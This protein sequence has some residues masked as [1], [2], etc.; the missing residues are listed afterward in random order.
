MNC[1]NKLMRTSTDLVVTDK[2]KFLS[3]DTTIQGDNK[4]LVICMFKNTSIPVVKQP[5]LTKKNVNLGKKNAP[6]IIFEPN[7][8][9]KAAVIPLLSDK[10]KVFGVNLEYEKML[11]L[12]IIDCMSKISKVD[13]DLEQ[14]R[15]DFESF[16]SEKL[17]ETFIQNLAEKLGKDIIKFDNV[18]PAGSA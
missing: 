16:Y 17:G 9:E 10:M 13:G 11:R 8:Y 3:K 5:D 1:L 18:E 14:I 6:K 12:N 4:Y 2:I 7:F 15:E